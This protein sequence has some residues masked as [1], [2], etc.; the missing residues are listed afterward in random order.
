M[1]EMKKTIIG[2]TKFWMNVEFQWVFTVYL[3]TYATS[4]LSGLFL[5]SN[6]W[7]DP[8][9]GKL[10]FTFVVNSSASMVKDKAMAERLGK[11][12]KR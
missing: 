3:L 12:K 11:G 1:R 6:E 9:M 2:S 8:L 5:K 10:L 4:N 7:I